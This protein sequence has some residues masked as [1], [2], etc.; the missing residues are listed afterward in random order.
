MEVRSLEW[1]DEAALADL[2]DYET[3]IGSDLVRTDHDPIEPSVLTPWQMYDPDLAPLLVPCLAR[4]L[5]RNSGTDALLAATIRNEDTYQVFLEYFGV[6]PHWLRMLRSADRSALTGHSE[7]H[8][9]VLQDLE[10]E[11][12]EAGCEI[13]GGYEE[14]ARVQ[15]FRVTT[16]RA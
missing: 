9:L 4:L 16:T 1:S 2:P 14:P 11:V 7:K 13:V 6:R 15:L 12:P 3:I 10:F 8:G 5:A